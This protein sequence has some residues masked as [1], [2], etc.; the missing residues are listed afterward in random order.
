MSKLTNS[1]FQF[2]SFSFL[3][4]LVVCTIEVSAQFDSVVFVRRAWHWDQ[5]VVY[6]GD[7]NNDGYDDFV[8]VEQDSA[9]GEYKKW[10]FAHFF[11]G[12]ESFI[13]PV[14]MLLPPVM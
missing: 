7:Q 12:G 10:G 8:L 14:L 6:L 1:P 3:L 2:V 4:L 5:S 13:L 9:N 11:Y